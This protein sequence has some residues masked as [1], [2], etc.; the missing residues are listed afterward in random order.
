MGHIAQN[1]TAWDLAYNLPFTRTLPTL[2]S[3]SSQPVEYRTVRQDTVWG[4]TPTDIKEVVDVSGIAFVCD[5]QPSAILGVYVGF[6]SGEKACADPRTS[7]T[8]AKGCCNPP[9]I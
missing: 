8:Q 7:S 3:V 5:Y 2:R 4:I 6:V 1:V 9:T